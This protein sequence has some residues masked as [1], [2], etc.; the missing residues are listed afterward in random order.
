[1]DWTRFDAATGYKVWHQLLEHVPFWNIEKTIQHSIGLESLVG[2][3]Y[4]NNHKC[5]SCMIGKSTLETP[6]G[7]NEPDSKPMA[8][9]HMEFN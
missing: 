3:K 7:S 5:P 9:V 2:K 1:M 8:L 6:T 4:P